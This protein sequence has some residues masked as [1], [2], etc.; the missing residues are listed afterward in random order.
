MECTG[1]CW[2]KGKTTGL[3]RAKKQAKN[4]WNLMVISGNDK[5]KRNRR[6]GK[7]E[8]IKSAGIV[9]FAD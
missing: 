5:M 9:K 7:Q 2:Q 8:E 3:K 1:M 6:K 4:D